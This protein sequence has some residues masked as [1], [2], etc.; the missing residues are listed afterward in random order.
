MFIDLERANQRAQA[1]ER[2]TAVLQDQLIQLQ[3]DIRQEEPGRGSPSL[4]DPV[5]SATRRFFIFK[6]KN[7]L[8]LSLGYNQGGLQRDVVYL[9]WPIAP[10]YTGGGGGRG[11]SANEYSLAHHVTKSPNKLWRST[12]IFNLWVPYIYIVLDQTLK[13]LSSEMDPAEIRLI[14]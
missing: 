6:W 1:A 8:F 5:G 7:A 4:P 14:R 2:E 13:V 12:S 3:A 10:S 11:V 9:C